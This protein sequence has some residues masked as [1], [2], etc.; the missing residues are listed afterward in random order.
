MRIDPGG[1]GGQVA[2][3]M[4][5]EL[6]ALPATID[7]GTT[8]RYTRTLGAY[9]ASAGWT[10]K[11]YLAGASV[12]NVDGVPDGDNF[13]VTIP[14]GTTA[15]LLKGTYAW[16]ERVTKSGEIYDAA[17]GTV[18]VRPNV[19]TASAGDFQSWAEKT[20]PIVEAA[21]AGQLDDGMAE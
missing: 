6:T 13:I 10:L 21:I 5:T 14:A 3:T 16:T 17:A 1:D 4:S 9:P 15:T 11:L 8:V 7:A 19:A 18:L 12:V 20:L 2:G